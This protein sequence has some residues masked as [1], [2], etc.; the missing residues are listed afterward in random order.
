MIYFIT[1]NYNSADLIAELL[2]SI[3]GQRFDPQTGA[4]FAYKLIVVNNSLAD[5]AIAAL[6]NANPE[7]VVLLQAWENLG[8]GRA[9]NLGLQWLYERDRKAIAWIINPDASLPAQAVAQLCEL[10]H[11]HP[12]V[13]ILGTA[14]AEVSG[15]L[16]F[17]GGKFVKQTGVIMELIAEREFDALSAERISLTDW[18]TACSLVLNLQQ[19]RECP[20]FDSDYFLY[21]E[22]FDFCRRYQ[23]QGHSIY[24][25][26]QIQVLHQVSAITSRNPNSKIKHQTYS[27]LLSLEKHTSSIVLG[28]RMIRIAIASLW[29]LFIYPQLA[30]NKLRG[31]GMYCQRLY[32]NSR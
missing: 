13:S 27:Y 32:S 11:H 22:D 14:V 24:I 20:Y 31:L 25:A 21:Y 23:S 4:S 6:A 7:S 12:E 5:Q 3:G 15:K 29:Q 18:V 2:G 30:T 8:F 10:L 17:S 26:P 16:C 9:C 1:V 19:F 28:F